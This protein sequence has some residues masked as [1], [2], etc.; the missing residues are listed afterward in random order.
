MWHFQTNWW[1]NFCA[2]GHPIC[3]WTNCS[4]WTNFFYS[5]IITLNCF[6]PLLKCAYVKY[7]W[8]YC[9]IVNLTN[10]LTWC[11]LWAVW[12]MYSCTSEVMSKI[13][14]TTIYFLLWVLLQNSELKVV[15][16][17]ESSAKH[18]TNMSLHF[19]NFIQTEVCGF[20]ALICC[21]LADFF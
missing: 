6:L 2:K 21:H 10:K 16:F 13:Y 11:F 9:L 18:L 4:M 14:S 7:L 1:S 5:Y 19:F 15:F 8:M 3:K 17:T 20:F 12:W